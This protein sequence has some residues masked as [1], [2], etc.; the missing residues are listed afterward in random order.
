MQEGI[1]LL[2]DFTDTLNI[3]ILPV[4][5]K[6]SLSQPRLMKPGE[7]SR[8]LSSLAAKSDK[9]LRDSILSGYITLETKVVNS[10]KRAMIG[11]K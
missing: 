8:F 11:R 6:G 5:S 10:P 2:F 9:D 4:T 1:V 3:N 7:H